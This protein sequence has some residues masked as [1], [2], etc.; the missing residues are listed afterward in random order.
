MRAIA[1]IAIG[2]ILVAI[3]LP[4]QLTAQNRAPIDNSPAASNPAPLLNPSG[5]KASSRLDQSLDR[6]RQ[7]GGR[8]KGCLIPGETR[9]P[10]PDTERRSIAGGVIVPGGI[11]LPK[12]GLP[13][14]RGVPFPKP[15]DVFAGD[16]PTRRPS[17]GGA[18]TLPKINSFLM[19]AIGQGGDFRFVPDPPGFLEKLLRIG[20]TQPSDNAFP[21]NEVALA[22]RDPAL[23][24]VGI[25]HGDDQLLCTGVL[26]G[27]RHVLT[28]GHCGCS[29]QSTY[30]VI[31][32]ENARPPNT[33][34]KLA[35][36]PILFDARS[37]PET[38]RPRFG[39]DL[40]LLI[41]KDT[42]ACAQGASVR[43]DRAMSAATTKSRLAD[44]VVADCDPPGPARAGNRI[45]FGYPTDLFAQVQ[46]TLALGQRL[47][48]VGYGYTDSVNLG[49]RAQATI[50]IKSMACT[51]PALAR[52]CQP[53]TEM[54][55]ADRQ[56]P[57][58]ESDSCRGDSGGPVFLTN[59]ENYTLVGITSRAGPG[60]QS[61]TV[62][63]CGGG[64]IY[65]LVGRQSVLDWLRLNG[66]PDAQR[67]LLTPQARN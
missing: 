32:G 51:E 2:S 44:P 8:E 34:V 29:N 64:G 9:R 16:L 42:F 28:A 41:L 14:P 6:A 39:K 5:R 65:T 21:T 40:A 25:R 12:G 15:G 13:V 31:L 26:I 58:I 23:L 7:C 38:D 53:F 4:R 45:T 43:I 55:L 1:A 57:G 24:A 20:T 46:A 48:V 11:D 52:F 37:C 27:P 62:A 59:G 56:G 22:P 61:D 49:L 47:L 54:L 17:A 18:L 35:Q 63:H 60:A 10:R 33:G 19:L 30:E 50:P 3:A 67:I 66:V 36:S